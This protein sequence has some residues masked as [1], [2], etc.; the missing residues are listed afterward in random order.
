M[1]GNFAA[2]AR[3]QPPSSRDA[4]AQK[5]TA[6]ISVI[7][8]AMIYA[9]YNQGRIFNNWGSIEQHVIHTIHTH[10]TTVQEAYR[11]QARLIYDTTGIRVGNYGQQADDIS[12]HH[13]DPTLNP[14]LHHPTHNALFIAGSFLNC[15]LPLTVSSRHLFTVEAFRPWV[16]ALC[17]LPIV[18][19]DP[20]I[21]DIYSIAL[22]ERDIIAYVNGGAH[23]LSSRTRAD[24]QHLDPSPY[25]NLITSFIHLFKFF[26]RM[27][28]Y[29]L[30]T[31][32]PRNDQRSI[33]SARRNY[34]QL[35]VLLS[36]I[37]YYI[38]TEIASDVSQLIDPADREIRRTYTAAN[39][40]IRVLIQQGSH[41]IMATIMCMSAIAAI[42]LK[43]VGNT[44]VYTTA[45]AQAGAIFRSLDFLGLIP[46]SAEHMECYTHYP[47]PAHEHYT[48]LSINEPF[49]IIEDEDTGEKAEYYPSIPLPSIERV[50]AMEPHA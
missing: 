11:S 13:T 50:T 34:M 48:A 33:D 16:F 6:L 1:I 26:M 15:L 25:D 46:N 27:V 7:N 41:P 22:R 49:L 4:R 47:I 35:G 10:G 44:T 19:N 43:V 21:Y 8:Q 20:L 24:M 32:P 37:I 40:L 42:V 36:D 31:S 2:A 18:R 29:N 39:E 12:S 17:T 5:I 3:N 23:Y 45:A 14:Q 30:A 9:F 28:I 38:G